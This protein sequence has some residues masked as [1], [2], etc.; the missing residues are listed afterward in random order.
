MTRYDPFRHHRRSIRLRGYDYARCAVYFVTLCSKHRECVFGE[1]VDGRVELSDAGRVVVD[2]WNEL[3]RHYAGVVLDEMQMM[4]NHMHGNIVLMDRH[5][6][7]SEIVRGLKTF[8]ARRINQLRG[9]PGVPV[10]QRNYYERIV[11]DDNELQR[12]RVYIRNNPLD[13]DTD[14]DNPRRW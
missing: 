7:L 14:P 11:R 1:V 3:P 6:A 5:H 8:S 10:W 4:P 12:T 9:T 13:W 2:T